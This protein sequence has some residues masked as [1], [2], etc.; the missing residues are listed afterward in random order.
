MP[1]NKDEVFPAPSNVKHVDSGL[2]GKE[3]C[4][5]IRPGHFNGVLTVVNRIFELINL[6]L[7]IWGS[8]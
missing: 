3:L 1:I 6:M 8:L 7:F 2:L 5:K 4:G